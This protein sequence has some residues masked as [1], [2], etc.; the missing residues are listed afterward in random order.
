MELKLQTS[1]IEPGL[2]VIEAGAGTGK[3]YSISHL[4]PRLLLEGALPDLGKLLLV[5]FTKDAARELSE[6][7]RRVLTRLAA[8]PEPDEAAKAPDL[9]ALRGLLD[10]ARNPAAPA[11]RARLERA[12]LDLDLLSV[13]TIHALCQRTLQQE[14]SLCGLPVL[15]E[16]V[17]DD[18]AYLEPLVRK[19][20]IETLSADA[21]L[22][23]LATAQGWDLDAALGFINT[24]RR[25]QRVRSEPA[26]EAYEPLRA[27]LDALCAALASA[28][29]QRAL[30]V[31]LEKVTAWNKSATFASVSAALAPL[32]SPA[33]ATLAFW[34]AIEEIP[35]LP[36]RIAKRRPADKA[37]AAALPT[38]AWFAAASELHALTARLQWAWQHALAEHALPELEATLAARR[39]ITQDGLIGAL[40][41]AL[42]RRGPDGATQSA[43]LAA[44]LAERYH[45]ALIDESQ[46]TDPRQFAIFRRIF[47]EASSRSRLLLV[48]VMNVTASTKVRTSSECRTHRVQIVAARAER[49]R[50]VA[51]LCQ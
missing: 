37:L 24:L 45:V 48:G 9:A 28:A 34:Q 8:P 16:V 19:R 50:A 29:D 35:A 47:L 22:A 11:A 46:D 51:S 25:C 2:T 5:T 39:L 49:P 13:S 38:L 20:W 14:G 21:S 1:P 27:R 15:P 10:P 33:P 36:D 30:L 17:T 40:Y 43:R 41:R 6:R 26:V 42:H 7:V 18:S 44:R 4:V 31:H 23:A 32:L 12:L 3:T